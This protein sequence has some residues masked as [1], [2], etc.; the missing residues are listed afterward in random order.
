MIRL[1]FVAAVLRSCPAGYKAK[2]RIRADTRVWLRCQFGIKT[3]LYIFFCGIAQQQKPNRKCN[4][5]AKEQP[6]E[7]DE[8]LLR[9]GIQRRKN[10]NRV[11]NG[12]REH[13]CNGDGHCN[14]FFNEAAHQ[15]NGSAFANGKQSPC[16][17]RR[18]KSKYLLSA[19]VMVGKENVIAYPMMH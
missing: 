9:K 17:K 12:R 14:A 13:K 3:F 16:K 19:Y 15:R 4:Q 5:Q 2:H 8:R 1:K 18:Y 11:D 10:R 7:R 6:I